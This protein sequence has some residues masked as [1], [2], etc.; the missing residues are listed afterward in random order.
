MLKQPTAGYHIP[1]ASSSPAG[2]PSIGPTNR[3]VDTSNHGL[4]QWVDVASHACDCRPR[5]PSLHQISTQHPTKHATAPQ[6]SRDQ[7]SKRR[8]RCL[9]PGDRAGMSHQGTSDVREV[10]SAAPTS[11]RMV[12]T[13]AALPHRNGCAWM[14]DLH[15]SQNRCMLVV[16]MAK[17]LY[18]IL[19]RLQA[20]GAFLQNG[21]KPMRDDALAP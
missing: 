13:S 1:I 21:S 6:A 14:H 11:G 10:R 7:G 20:F 4:P 8:S 5:T 2:L 17:L 3:L 18:V 19:Y 15:F 12:G 9:E 16:N